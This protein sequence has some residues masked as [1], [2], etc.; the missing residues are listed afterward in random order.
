M[1]RGGTRM[2][3]LGPG[4]AET[5]RR[6]REETKVMTRFLP[7][8]GICVPLGAKSEDR[9]WWHGCIAIQRSP[10]QTSICC[11]PSSWQSHA[12]GR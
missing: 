10:L 9:V 12:F 3:G 6:L 8:R 2:G 1:N 4:Q 7:C 5:K 11:L